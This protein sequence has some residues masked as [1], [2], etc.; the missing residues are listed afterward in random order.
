MRKLI[1]WNVITLDGYFEG[2]KAWDLDFHGLV[3]GPEME[4]FVAEQLKTI[5]TIVFGEKTY[6]GMA[7][8]W[9]KAKGETAEYMNKL[10]KIVCS[11]MLATADWNNTT[12]VRDAVAELSKMKEEGDGNMFVFGSGK[13]SESLMKADLFDEYRLCIAPIFLGK[14]GRLFNEGLP[15]QKLKLLEARPLQTGGVILRY[16]RNS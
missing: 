5:D 7:D 13:L 16:A 1:M 8:Y 14:G 15:Y 11:T 6:K 3:W 9:S 12:I 10:P 2:E 4:Q